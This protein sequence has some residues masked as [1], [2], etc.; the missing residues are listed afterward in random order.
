M[1]LFISDLDGTLLN[2]NKEI[3]VY[4]KKV[5]NNLINEGI[6]FTVA[7]ARTPAT[8]IDILKDLSIKL[9][10]ILMNGVI[11]YDINEK[12]Y[13]NIESVERS[14]V[15]DILK[16]FEKNNKSPL[17]YGINDD[18]LYV[19]YK[20]FVYEVE[21]DFYKERC[22]SPYKTFLKVDEYIESTKASKIINFIAYDKLE[23][24]K[25]IYDELSKLEGIT[26]DYYEEIYRKG[27]YYLDAYS[28]KAS[29]ANGIKFLSRYVQTDK[30]ICFGDNLNDIPMFKVS[31]ESYAVNNANDV[32]KDMATAVIEGNNDDAVAKF[33]EKRVRESLE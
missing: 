18:E 14:L 12:R 24:I 26:V 30:V 22:H 9:P 28:S 4:S 5:L 23:V 6:N 27:W 21:K 16:V 20:E 7:T 13:I 10:V 3:S 33:I 1:E 31:D 29:K 32:L 11:I 15:Q 17:V 25:N 19:Y 8:V 2:S